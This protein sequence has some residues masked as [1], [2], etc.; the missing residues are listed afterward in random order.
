MII[1][2]YTVRLDTSSKTVRILIP[3]ADWFHLMFMVQGENTDV[4]VY[5]NK[6]V[7]TGTLDSSSSDFSPSSGKTIIGKLTSDQELFYGS[8]IVDELAMWNYALSEAKVAQIYD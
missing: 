7:Q 8:V 1:C 3:S 5:H 2:S 6:A 4:T